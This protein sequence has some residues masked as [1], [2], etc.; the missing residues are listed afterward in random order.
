[1]EVLTVRVSE[2][3]SSLTKM[4]SSTS[5]KGKNYGMQIKMGM[6]IDLM[7]LMQSLPLRGVKIVFIELGSLSWSAQ[8]WSKHSPGFVLGKELHCG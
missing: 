4:Q 5:G 3:E 8:G 7:L 1:M 2:P 6:I